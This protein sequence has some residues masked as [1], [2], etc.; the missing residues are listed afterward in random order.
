[1]IQ[2]DMAAAELKQSKIWHNS[3]WK[4]KERMNEELRAT[5]ALLEAAAVSEMAACG[6]R[7]EDSQRDGVKV[8]KHQKT[9][10]ARPAGTRLYSVL[11]S[12]PERLPPYAVQSPVVKIG[13]G[14]LNIRD[15]ML[16]TGKDGLAGQDKEV[17][18]NVRIEK[19]GQTGWERRTQQLQGA[20]KEKLRECE[21]GESENGESEKER[22][23]SD[24]S[25]TRTVLRS[26]K[27]GQKEGNVTT[28]M[29]R[30][31]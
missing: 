13:S 5:A 2:R 25:E 23:Q 16:K 20:G 9:T 30:H 21:E 15:G 31:P 24:V 1:M 10:E 8:E 22:E 17:C 18:K 27:K 12:S 11:P 29:H 28:A 19:S 26:K 4:K 14:V 3:K 7:G 6:L